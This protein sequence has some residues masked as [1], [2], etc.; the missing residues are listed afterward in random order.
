MYTEKSIELKSD[1][2]TRY[3][4]AS[5]ALYFERTGIPCALM[6]SM[7][8]VL[9]FSMQCGVRAYG[10]RYG[11]IIKIMNSE[12]N[13]FDI[14][15][16]DNGCGAQILYKQDLKNIKR[17]DE[18][19]DYT[20]EKLL[21]R[22]GLKNKSDLKVSLTSICDSLG[23]DGWCAY[24][25]N[26]RMQQVPLPMYDYHVLIIRT[27]KNG[28]FRT[29]RIMRMQFAEDEARRIKVAAEGLKKC[30]TEVL[31][32]MMNESERSIERLLMPSRQAVMAVEAARCA[33]GVAAAKICNMGIVCFVEKDKT[34]SA[35]HRINTDFEKNIGYSAG[36]ITVN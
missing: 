10:R 2:Y 24:C 34:D 22:M 8:S 4:E 16:V 9:A 18:V 36:I 29:D 7:S 15:F 25:D 33:D 35:I 13:V 30:R 32:E 27:Q 1:F 21:V 5:G 6:E 12:Q 28:R 20:I 26:G 19:T 3:G 17:M 31:F 14:H 23:K 11:D